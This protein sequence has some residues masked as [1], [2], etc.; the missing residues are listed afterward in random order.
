MDYNS[1]RL[2]K[3][4]EGVLSCLWI[5]DELHLPGDEEVHPQVSLKEKILFILLIETIV[6]Y[7]GD[8]IITIF[9][10]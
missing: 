6:L 2:A 8:E 7:N 4:T 10:H 5:R 3:H 9:L 1:T